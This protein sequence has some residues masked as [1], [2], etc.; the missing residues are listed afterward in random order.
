[1]LV[2]IRSEEDKMNHGCLDLVCA[3]LEKEFP[4]FMEKG[5]GRVKRWDELH[6]ACLRILLREK[7][8]FL[9]NERFRPET[10]TEIEDVLRNWQGTSLRIRFCVVLILQTLPELL[11]VDE[12]L[13]SIWNSS[14][15]L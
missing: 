1:L 2:K 8:L 15:G 14:R 4:E 6:S 10:L 13:A 9:K 3:T 11:R 5:P 7:K 12:A